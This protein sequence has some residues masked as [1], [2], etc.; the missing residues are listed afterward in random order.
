MNPNLRNIKMLSTLSVTGTK[1]PAK[2]P[3]LSVPPTGLGKAPGLGREDSLPES[4]LFP[5]VDDFLALD[6]EE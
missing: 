1:T 2:V 6:L 4:R 3:N 5:A